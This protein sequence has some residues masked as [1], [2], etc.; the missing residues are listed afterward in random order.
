MKRIIFILLIL[1]SSTIVGQINSENVIGFLNKDQLKPTF[2]LIQEGEKKRGGEVEFNAHK[3]FLKGKIYLLNKQFVQGDSCFQFVSSIYNQIEKLDTACL[4]NSALCLK[5]M[6]K[7]NA[8]ISKFNQCILKGYRSIDSYKEI[9]F[10]KQELKMYDDALD[11]LEI[12]QMKQVSSLELKI[13]E[14]EILVAKSE[15]EKALPLIEKAILIDATNPYLYSYKGVILHHQDGSD[16]A[17]INS[18]NKCLSIDSNN[19]NCLYNLGM[20]KYDL[21]LSSW[22]DAQETMVNSVKN[23]KKVLYSEDGNEV[24]ELLERIRFIKPNYLN[25]E[26]VILDVQSKIKP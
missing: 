25:V 19:V 23:E 21:F 20:I 15:Y 4:F 22:K 6:K 8:S 17:A 18:L 9:V 26:E 2:E 11:I 14:I 7:Y 24:L 5:G 1:I 10:I 13:A 3:V 16:N 12:A